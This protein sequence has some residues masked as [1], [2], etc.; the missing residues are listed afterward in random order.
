MRRTSSYPKSSSAYK[1]KVIIFLS[2][3]MSAAEDFVNMH[4]KK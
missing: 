3:L 4:E 2:A 1:L